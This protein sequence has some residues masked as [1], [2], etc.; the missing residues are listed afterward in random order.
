[1]I[2]SAYQQ[3]VSTSTSVQ[4]FILQC[5][6][7]TADDNQMNQIYFRFLLFNRVQI[8]VYENEESTCRLNVEKWLSFTRLYCYVAVCQ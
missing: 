7:K 5:Q 2:N 6:Q 1:M 3:S 4:V 8:S